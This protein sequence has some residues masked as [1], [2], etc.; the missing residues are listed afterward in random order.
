MVTFAPSVAAAA[1]PTKPVPEPISRIFRVGDSE[2]WRKAV[3][4]GVRGL[5]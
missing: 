1:I 4:V 2:V 3:R 5:V